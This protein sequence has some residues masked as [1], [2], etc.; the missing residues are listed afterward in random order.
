MNYLSHFSLVFAFYLETSNLICIRNQMTGFYMK[1][2]A[3]L[4]WANVLNAVLSVLKVLCVF[5]SGV[6]L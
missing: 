6:V 2:D 5:S 3:A 4:I 1:C